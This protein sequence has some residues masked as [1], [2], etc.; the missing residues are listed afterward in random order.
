[1][2]ARL[3][4]PSSDY[5]FDLARLLDNADQDFRW[6]ELEQGWYSG[7]LNGNIVHVRQDGDHLEYR[8]NANLDSLLRSYFRLDEDVDAIYAELSSMDPVMATLAQDYPWLRVLRQPDPWECTVAYICSAPNN[9]KGISRIVE[10]IAEG[11][12]KPVQLGQDVRYTFPGPEQVLSAGLAPL[13]DMQLGLDRDR[14]ILEAAG[15][16]CSRELDL[17]RL[18]LPGTPY[19]EAKQRLMKLYGVKHKVADCIALFSLD[20]PEAFP[21]DTHIGRALMSRYGVPSQREA[22]REAAGEFARKHFG[23]YAGWAS[24]LLFQSQRSA[25][26]QGQRR[27]GQI[28]PCGRPV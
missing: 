22:E 23:R 17:S 3:P 13:R 6:R 2:H 1:M 28:A 7:V 4:I 15:Q 27:V 14:R 25:G 8:A 11:L 5:P 16:V 19:P 12:G 10:K 24:Q 26:P 18:S 21:V 20:K 9:V